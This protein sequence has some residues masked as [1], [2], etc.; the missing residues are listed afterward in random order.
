MI[1]V[2]DLHKGFDDVQVLKGITTTFEP[3]KTSLIIGQSGSGKTV[4]LKS[5]IGLHT[6]EEG[7]IAFDGRVNTKFTNEEKRQ[8]RQ[9]IGMVFQGSALFDSQTVEENV[10]FPLK[11]FTD[12]SQSEMLDR[13]NF[14]LNR[15]N[16]ENSNHKLPAELSG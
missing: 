9:E 5:L 4:F 3:G 7:T 14:V 12:Q 15:V 8:W 11:M 13:V 1:E 2:K 16:L 10:M 6:P